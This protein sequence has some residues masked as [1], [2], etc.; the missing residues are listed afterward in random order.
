MT[1]TI[2]PVDSTTQS[3][4]RDGAQYKN[5]LRDSRS[6]WVADHKVADVTQEPTLGPG[7]DLMGTMFDDQFNPEYRDV[8][9]LTDPETGERYSRSWQIPRT[10]AELQDRRQ[11]IEY[12]S[13]K[14]AGTFGRPPDLSPLIALGMYSRSPLF[15]R[16]PAAFSKNNHDFAENIA[17]YM[18]HGRDTNIIAA[19]VL[20]DPQNDRSGPSGGT[21]GLLR[22]VG[23]TDDGIVVSGAK[24]VGSI[25]AQADEILFTNLLRP[26]LP[27]EAC[28][29]AATRV[30]NPGVKLICREAVSSPGADP[31]DHPLG[32][33]GEE[34]DQFIVFDNAFIPNERVFNVGD[35]EL[36]KLYGPCS[37]WGHWHVLTRMWVKAE[38]F[39]GVAQLITEFLGTTKI[40]QVRNMVTEVIAYA[41]TLKAFVLTAENQ[42]YL[43]E[44]GVFG[45]DINFLTAGRL[46]SID[47][48]PRII[49]ILQE[50][51]GQGLVMRFPRAAFD[52][53]EVGE[54]LEQLLPGH[55]V[56]ARD[57]NR[58]MNFVWDLTASSL[59][60]RTA[61]F[62]NVN[63]TPAPFIRERLYR[64]FDRDRM[65]GMAR[66]LAGLPY[67]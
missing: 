39:V 27:P 28:V 63:S 45:A 26:D 18:K 67:E 65:V 46:H 15:K 36:L 29:W 31:F 11:L 23:Q 60:G 61:V 14:T 54:Y 13:F 37:Q 56:T 8:L 25:A 21:A 55:G 40:P 35:T 44:G 64:E 19:E 48:Y 24:S 30:D 3:H 51:C 17:K 20:A 5:D 16:S 7:I 50:L 38:I 52:S 34:A 62:E 1:A 9:T 4:L 42:G 49:H 53:D 47:H 66:D 22:I 32:Y 10:L 57:K 12:T 58:L 2:E 41:Q 43:T 33:K 6:V 59:A